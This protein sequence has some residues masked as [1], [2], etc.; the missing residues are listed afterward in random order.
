MD[1]T[2]LIW[3]TF[4]RSGHRHCGTGR[5]ASQRVASN[6]L[7][8]T[9][10]CLKLIACV[11]AQHPNDLPWFAFPKRQIQENKLAS[12]IMLGGSLKPWPRHELEGFGKVPAL[13]SSFLCP[14]PLK[15]ASYCKESFNSIFWS[16]NLRSIFLKHWAEGTCLDCSLF[17]T[18]TISTCLRLSNSTPS[19]SN[20]DWLVLTGR[21]LL[22]TRASL[23]EPYPTSQEWAP[24]S[25]GWSST[26]LVAW[27][28]KE[29][30]VFWDLPQYQVL[31]LEKGKKWNGRNTWSGVQEGHPKLG[32][33][34]T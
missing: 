20:Q 18:P 13:I 10:N 34:H 22:Q 25:R 12:S 23:R 11:W 30:F 29:L 28:P 17:K 7:K 19:S 1:Q 27:N 31:N 3:A 2:S 33:S 9:W 8:I 15:W 24:A 26:K 5:P 32:L 14:R 16:L 4:L 21:A 6:H